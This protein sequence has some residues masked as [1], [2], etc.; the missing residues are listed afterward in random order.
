MENTVY[1]FCSKNNIYGSHKVSLYEI[2]VGHYQDIEPEKLSEES[3][4]SLDI[5]IP[6][7]LRHIDGTIEIK[8]FLFQDNKGS[9]LLGNSV[10][11]ENSVSLFC[12]DNNIQELSCLALLKE[13]FMIINK[14]H[15][16]RMRV[17]INTIP[18]VRKNPL[19]YVFEDLNIQHDLNTI[20]F[21]FGVY[22]GTTIN[23][24]SK[25]TTGIL[26]N[27]RFIIEVNRNIFRCCI[28]L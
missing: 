8:Y 13:A 23:Y 18:N 21:E 2:A 17:M 4:T 25:F 16:N 19:L 15:K 26:F 6:L 27:T 1:D 3:N 22:K 24:F 7:E 10:L 12:Y 14:R 11:L 9:V 5:S 28:W 20:W